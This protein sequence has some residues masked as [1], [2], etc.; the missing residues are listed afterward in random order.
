MSEQKVNQLVGHLF[1]HE[2]GKMAAV[3]TRIVGIQ[4]L[5]LAQDLVQDTLLKAINT[6]K[7]KGIPE[8]PSGW[9]YTVAKRKAIDA[10][11]QKK[12]HH[13]IESDLARAFQSEWTLAPTVKHLFFDHE[14]EDSQLRMMFACCHPSIPYES[15]IALTLK[16]LCGLSVSEIAHCFLTN[17]ETITKRLYRAKEK[18]RDEKIELE[19]PS[20]ATLTSRLETVLHGLYLLFTEGYNSSHPK[21]L[22]RHDLC[23][24]AMRL[25][26]LLTKNQLTDQPNT[27]ALLA[28]MCF[29]ASR[30]DARLT[31]SGSIILLKHQDRKLWNRPLIDKGNEY[32][33]SSAQGEILSEYHLEAAIAACH[34][35]AAT[36]EET[37]WKRILRLYE[38]LSS[39]KSD[40]IVEMN[41]AIV[42]GFVETPSRGLEKLKSIKGLEHNSIYHAALGD[43]YHQT[44]NLKKAKLEYEH[45][46][47]LTRSNS[48]KDLLHKKI[49]E[50]A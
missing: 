43:L 22:I 26:L 36:F 41:Q 33:N 37:D 13:E 16:T 1:R 10:I 7:I 27:R 19:I 34:A 47:T 24:E 3:L 42:L 30:A 40:P 17:E 48:E 9:L 20:P 39:V 23:E 18:I 28:L 5:D 31:T 35:Q 44:K 25:C 46:I 38:I 11:R 2:S 49:S 14:I 32:L 6:W 8:N 12:I 29:Q 4:N 50:L 21:Q 15:Q 45:A